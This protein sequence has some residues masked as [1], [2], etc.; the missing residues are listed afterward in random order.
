[1]SDCRLLFWT[2]LL[3]LLSSLLRTLLLL[4]LLLCF[5]AD[6]IL[7]IDL[8]VIVLTTSLPLVVLFISVYCCLLVNVFCYIFFDCSVLICCA[9]HLIKNNLLYLRI[10]YI[11]N[12]IYKSSTVIIICMVHVPL[13]FNSSSSFHHNIIEASYFH[14]PSSFF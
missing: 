11:Y 13:L 1:M 5:I 9:I 6:V 2:P 10:P 14:I 3:L 12:R 7:A 4:L 8:L